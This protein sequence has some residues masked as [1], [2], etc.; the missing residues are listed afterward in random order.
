MYSEQS[1]D[2]H[3]A[4]RGQ[5]VGNVRDLLSLSLEIRK[6]KEKILAVTSCLFEGLHFQ[7]P[8]NFKQHA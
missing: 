5:Y 6:K 3:A 8:G 1:K 4:S 2:R 7:L